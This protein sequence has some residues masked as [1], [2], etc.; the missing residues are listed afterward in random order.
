MAERIH[1]FGIDIDALSMNEAVASI[2]SW[3]DA[4]D[5][6]S[7]YV[8]TPN[9]DHVVKLQKNPA[10]LSAYQGAR[11]VLAD[12]KPVVLA[13]RLLGKPLP[14]TVPGSDLVPALFEASKERGGLRVFL[15]GAAEGV[16]GRAA[17]TI[18]ARWPW[19]EVVGAVSPPMGFSATSPSHDAAVAQINAAQPD[20]LVVGLG[21]PKQEIWAEQ[22]CPDLRTKGVLCVGAT[23][24]FLAGEKARAPVWIRRLGFEWLHRALSEPK[25]LLG[26][27]LHDAWVFPRLFVREWLRG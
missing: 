25:R 22:A 26:R 8:V 21:A 27:Y 12:G 13:S 14:G 23:I 9:V 24:D 19:V 6:S 3:V 4:E 5:R 18:A 15:F 7:P 20:L 2:L 1:M 17:A 10:F 16:P 11:L